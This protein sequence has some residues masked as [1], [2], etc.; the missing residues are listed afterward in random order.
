MLFA[1]T[2]PLLSM[3][4]TNPTGSEEND[5]STVEEQE[6]V[7]F[8][9]T[10]SVYTEDW[11]NTVTFRYPEAGYSPK[12]TIE[13]VDSLF[14]YAFPVEKETTSGFGGRRG[15]KGVDIPLKTGDDV[16]AAFG[17]KVRYAQWN[18]GGF[19][20]LVIIRHPNGVETYYAHLS[21]IKVKPNQV[22]QAG[23]LIGLGGS[24]G[25]SYSPHLHFETRYH[26]VPF[27]PAHIFDLE[28]F[29]LKNETINLEEVIKSGHGTVA[30]KDVEADRD[31]DHAE[32][33]EATTA[34]TASTGSATS[35]SASS[36]YYS[37]RSGDSLSKIA[38]RYGTSV[39]NLCKLNGLTRQSILRIGQ[40]VRIQ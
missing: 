2:M 4:T 21:K 5:S 12:G 1:M 31:H 13:L 32:H 36:K 17:G 10:A 22:V 9:D 29:C 35:S 16:V 7:S 34:A 33:Q 6:K 19:G 28:N 37:V 39:D 8:Y 18:T 14:G 25:R 3:A 40:Q 30:A 38:A 20:N 24:T 26:H 15:H 11:Q 23:E 27:D